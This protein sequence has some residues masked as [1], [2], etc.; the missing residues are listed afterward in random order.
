MQPL[1]VGGEHWSAFAHVLRSRSPVSC[2]ALAVL[3]SALPGAALVVADIRVARF[4][5]VI[6]LVHLHPPPAPP[7][8]LIL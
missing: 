8:I 1:F 6:I 3:S 4:S 5:L 2:L 7:L